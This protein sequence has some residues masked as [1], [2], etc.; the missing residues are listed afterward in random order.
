MADKMGFNP[1]LTMWTKPKSTIRSIVNYDSN[2]RLFVLS[3]IYGFVSLISTAQSFSIGETLNFFLILLIAIILAPVWGFIAFSIS[4]F[5]IHFTGKWLKGQASYKEVRASIAW[6]NVPMIGNVVLWIILFVIF[7]QDILKDFPGSSALSGTYRG[8][9]LMI[10]FGQ[11]ILNIW[12]LVLYINSLAEVQRFSIGKAILNIIIA[13]II[14]IALFFI[15]SI[16][17]FLVLKGL[18]IR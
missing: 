4:S 10:L 8:I 5:F 15:V 11:L 12:V 2:F 13:V 18:N 7:K 9:L 6:S 17:Y 1:W 3:G 14:F 16:I